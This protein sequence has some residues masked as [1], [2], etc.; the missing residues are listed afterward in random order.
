MVALR[1][2]TAAIFALLMAAPAAHAVVEEHG[3][4][5]ARDGTQLRYSVERPDGE[6]PFP[7]LVN[8]E[9]Y[10][11]GSNPRDNGLATYA[12][13]LLERGYALVG[14]SVRGTGCSEGVFDPFARTMGT[15]GADAVE[16]A[17]DQPWSDGRVGMIGVSFGGITQL[18]T[19]A[20]RPPH[21]RAIAPSSALSDLYRDVAYPG[22]ILE[23]D[24]VFA[25]TVI[26]KQGGATYAATGAPQDGDADCVRNFATGQAQGAHPDFFIPSLVTRNPYNDDF[27]GEWVNRSPVRGFPDIRV[28]T[29]LLNAWQDEQLPARIFGELDRFAR[30]ERVWV[31]VTNG[32][33]GR[34]YSASYAQER[35]LDFLDRFVRGVD[36]GF[37]RRVKHLT[38][39]METHTSRDGES[40]VPTWMIERN[41]IRL[42]TAQ[43]RLYLR[44]DGALAEQEPELPEP[45]DSYVY[46][47]PSPDLTEPGVGT[48]TATFKVPVTPGGSAAYTT[49]PLADDLVV[50]GPAS[51]DLWL[52]STA[53]DTDIQVTLTE[54]RPD[55]QETYVQ[56]GWL[57]ASHRAL[58]EERSTTLRPYHTHLRGDAQPLEA[59]EPTFMRVEVF[60]FAHAF[61]EG[62]RLRLWIDAPTS[63]TGFWAFAPH[64]EPAVNTVLHDPE[65]PSSLVLGSLPREQAEAPMPDCDVLRNQPCR[66]DPLTG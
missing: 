21:L 2:V 4:L 60:P 64:A 63:H 44:S 55:G 61:R 58:D 24:F 47:L 13:R 59:L 26:Q 53:S 35:T 49:E 46:P 65:H 56:R 16:W 54:V 38:L 32:N 11:A 19:A 5:E 1:A 33:H 23:Y 45:G 34:D 66:P 31:D 51:L 10:A 48:G 40:N 14:V 41:S 12:D 8:Y 43:K 18:L 50:A 20:E 30:P 57:R 15:D 27:D 37:E 22:G 7:V 28:P 6:G 9:G 42:R 52:S 29:Y 25:W 3:Y 62:S 39:A 36:N 17:A